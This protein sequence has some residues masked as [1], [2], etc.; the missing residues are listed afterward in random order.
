[1]AQCPFKEFPYKASPLYSHQNSGCL[2]LSEI[3]PSQEK[4]VCEIQ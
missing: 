3:F 1:M 4:T 2:H